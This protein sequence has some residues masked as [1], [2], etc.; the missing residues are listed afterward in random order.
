MI[1][2]IPPRPWGDFAGHDFSAGSADMRIGL[3][4]TLRDEAQALPRFQIA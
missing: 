1:S 2:A 3:L 4:A